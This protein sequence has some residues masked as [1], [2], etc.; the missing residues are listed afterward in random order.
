M[1]K[2]RVAKDEG[3][4]MMLQRFFSAQFL[5]F[6]DKKIDLAAHV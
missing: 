1:G 6:I 4:A 2:G 5:L 3:N